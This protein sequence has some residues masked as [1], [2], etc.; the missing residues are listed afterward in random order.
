MVANHRTRGL[1]AA[2]LVPKLDEPALGA[3]REGPVGC[4]SE[5]DRLVGA[6]R[7]MRLPDLTGRGVED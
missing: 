5:R 1:K 3:G 7:M 6:E 4:E 2:G